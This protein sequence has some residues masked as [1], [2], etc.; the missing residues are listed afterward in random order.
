MQRPIAKPVATPV[1]ELDTPALLVDVERL[2]ANCAAARGQGPV[3]VEA[4]VHKTPAIAWRQVSAL[5]DSVVGIAARGVAEAEVFAA[6][7]FRNIRILRPL[8]TEAAQR[9][10]EALARTID[11]VARDD[12]V[13]LWGADALAGAVSVSARVNGVPE[14]EAAYAQAGASVQHQAGV[15]DRAILD[16]G[17]KAVGRDFGDPRLVGH[18]GCRVSVGSAEHGVVL[19]P[20]DAPRF[21]IGEWLRLVPADIATAFS[22]HDFAYAIRGGVL[23]ATWPVSARGAFQ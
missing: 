18:D 22:L 6:A 21:A 3:R 19:L 5:G 11:V 23:E 14:A 17:Q 16:C 13:P 8:A 2:D 9:R 12:G 10:A 15:G 7:G 1:E 20:D 4:W